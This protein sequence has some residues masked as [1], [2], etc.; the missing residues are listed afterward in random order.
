MKAIG[1]R[2]NILYARRF[3]DRLKKRIMRKSLTSPQSY[4]TEG[5]HAVRTIWEFDDRYTAPLFGFGTAENYYRTQSS[6]QF[7]RHIRVPTL[8]VTSKDDP[9]V[10]FEIFEHPSLKENPAIT[11]AATE[12]GGHLGFLAKTKP[13][14]WVERF[15]LQWVDNVL[16]ERTGEGTHP[17]L[18]AAG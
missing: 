13:R 2:A 14:F 16:H 18:V 7:L 4:T 6:Q 8:I 3:L 11:L 10:P 1:K 15:V 5:L 12:H 17:D 9:L